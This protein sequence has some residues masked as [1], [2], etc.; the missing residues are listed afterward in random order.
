[1]GKS[2]LCVICEPITDED[3]QMYA[4][5]LRQDE[6]SQI[7]LHKSHIWHMLET[8]QHLQNLQAGVKAEV[9]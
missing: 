3:L 7:Q 4:G 1:M 9:E 2:G 6:R 5:W 8:I